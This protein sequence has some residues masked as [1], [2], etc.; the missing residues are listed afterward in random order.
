[1][2]KLIVAAAS[3]SFTILALTGCITIS[4]TAPAPPETV[5]APPEPSAAPSPTK[6]SLEDFNAIAAENGTD[7]TG[8]QMKTIGEAICRAFGRG[9]SFKD[10][11]DAGIDN[12]GNAKLYGKL[13]GTSVRD[14][15][16]EYTADVLKS[17]DAASL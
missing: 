17:M 9:A 1:M 2:K 13:M 11:L 15:C 16:P 10:V 7:I 8:E 3:A 5:S 4:P 12:F 6:D 14:L